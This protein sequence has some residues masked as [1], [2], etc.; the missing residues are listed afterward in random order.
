[1][2]DEL[3]RLVTQYDRG[4]LSRRQL[5]QGLLAIGVGAE[6]AGPATA[7]GQVPAPGP[8]FMAHTLNH[9]TLFADDVPRSK[10]LYQSLTGLA[11]R[12]E[13]KDFCEFRLD[14]G[15]L[16]IYGVEK[17]SRPGFDHFCFG[18]DGFEPK[19]AFAALKAALPDA[20]PRINVGDGQVYLRDPDGV[21][22]Q[23]ADVNYKR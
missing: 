17:G 18:V 22:V 20:K 19:S 9:V 13:A 15:F 14:G 2:I 21:T 6:L 23:I 12:D 7:A 3:G 4:G 10:A 5:L 11:V 16:G 1:M 8:V